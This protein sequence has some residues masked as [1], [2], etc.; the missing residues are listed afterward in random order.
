VAIRACFAHDDPERASR[1][2]ALGLKLAPDHAPYG[3]Y[4]RILEREARRP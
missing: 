1:L 3:Y 2:V 4:G